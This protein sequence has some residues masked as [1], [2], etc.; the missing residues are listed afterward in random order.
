MVDETRVYNA[1]NDSEPERG[2]VGIKSGIIKCKKLLNN[3]HFELGAGGFNQV[4]VEDMYYSVLRK[5]NTKGKVF[6][7]FLKR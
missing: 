2:E 4:S 5:G 7:M 6:L 3:L 1:W